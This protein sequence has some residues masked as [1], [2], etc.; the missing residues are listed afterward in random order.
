LGKPK[1]KRVGKKNKSIIMKN[2]IYITLVL[3]AFTFF[4]NCVNAQQAE[5][6][7]TKIGKSR[8]NIQNNKTTTNITPALCTVVVRCTDGSCTVDYANANSSSEKRMH[9]PFVI[10]KELDAV[11]PRD[12]GSGLATGKTTE[13]SISEVTAKVMYEDSWSA[14]MKL[15]L[16]NGEYVLPIECKNGKCEIE[17]SWSW[18]ASNSR[19]T[20]TYT[21]GRFIL[22]MDNGICTDMTIKSKDAFGTK[23]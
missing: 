3:V 2:R 9:K 13:Q 23:N 8:S 11:Q 6:S 10:I 21:G 12:T 15:L 5:M 17:L 20:R 19:S 18:G 1:T 4:T 16:I 7:S 22:E 14:P